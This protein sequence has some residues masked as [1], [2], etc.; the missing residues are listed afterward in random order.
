MTHLIV[1]EAEEPTDGDTSATPPPPLP[2]ALRGEEA[3]PAAERLMAAAE[4]ELTPPP[5]L[6]IIWEMLRERVPLLLAASVISFR[7]LWRLHILCEAG[8]AL[9]CAHAARAAARRGPISLQGGNLIGLK[10]RPKMAPEMT[11]KYFLKRFLEK[12]IY[13][14][15]FKLLE[16]PYCQLK[17]SPQNVPKQEGNG[18]IYLR[19]QGL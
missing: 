9:S 1:S 2:P 3:D 12:D 7:R 19:R 15:K 14:N 8:R 18:P 16:C 13:K 6:L 4:E 5:S 17:K 10:I 11:P